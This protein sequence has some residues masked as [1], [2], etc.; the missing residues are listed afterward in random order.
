MSKEYRRSTIVNDV[1]A[2]NPFESRYKPTFHR[3]GKGLTV[4]GIKFEKPF[5]HPVV[6]SY[7][8]FFA[9]CFANGIFDIINLSESDAEYWKNIVLIAA[10]A[11]VIFGHYR[12]FLKIYRSNDDIPCRPLIYT[13]LIAV[14]VFLIIIDLTLLMCL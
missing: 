9:L 4:Y 13:F 6:I 1:K 7:I 10:I 2:E 11:I 3:G 14:C 12:E 5:K 8:I